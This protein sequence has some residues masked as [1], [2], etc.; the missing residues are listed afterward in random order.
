MREVRHYD[1]VT[2]ALDQAMPASNVVATGGP[3]E[4]RNK[5][6]LVSRTTL[7]RIGSD[8]ALLIADVKT[9]SCEGVGENGIFTMGN[10]GN[11]DTGDA[12]IVNIRYATWGDNPERPLQVVQS[13]EEFAATPRKDRRGTPSAVWWDQ[14]ADRPDGLSE[15]RFLPIPAEGTKLTLYVW[16]TNLSALTDSGKSWM[17]PGE[18]DLLVSSLACDL[19][20]HIGAGQIPPSLLRR[21]HRAEATLRRSRAQTVARDAYTRSG[22]ASVGHHGLGY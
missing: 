14:G 16:E 19:C 10:G 1:I 20:S 11:F 22:I 18:M 2:M 5:A 15:V 13:F 4:E 12:S 3:E 6:L 9:V 8:P 17:V 7:D 21:Q